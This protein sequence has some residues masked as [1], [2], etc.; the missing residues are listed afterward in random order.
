M[1][2]I[3][4][5]WRRHR[6]LLDRCVP[7]VEAQTYAPVEHVIVSDGRDEGLAWSLGA[8]IGRGQLGNVTYIELPAHPEGEHWGHPGRLAG[9]EAALGDLIT[10]CDDDDALRPGHCALMAAALEADPGAGFAVSRMMSHHSRDP[11]R[12]Q[13]IGW[14][15]LAMGNVGT[16]MI[17]HRRWALEHGTWGPA[18]WTEDW[19]IV[20]RWLDAGV[21]YVNVDAETSD[22]WPSMYREG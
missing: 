19:D 14:G 3:T 21:R 16:S 8:R 22:V 9:I 2:V 15:P 5:T 18:S 6:L 1:S 7:S 13:V 12:K 10:Y 20:E 17:M 11:A 4:P